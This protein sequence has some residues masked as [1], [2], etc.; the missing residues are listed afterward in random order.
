MNAMDYLA[1]IEP[2][3]SAWRLIEK[4]LAANHGWLVWPTE[5]VAIDSANLSSRCDGI[6]SLPGVHIILQLIVQLGLGGVDGNFN[7]VRMPHLTGK[8]GLRL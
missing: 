8:S 7:H 6:P 4:K 5:K 3:S 2:G 1:G